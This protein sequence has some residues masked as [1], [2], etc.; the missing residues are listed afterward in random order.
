MNGTDGDI[1]RYFLQ[2]TQ[3]RM[4]RKLRIV[5]PCHD[6]SCMKNDWRKTIDFRRKRNDTSINTI[7]RGPK[8]KKCP[9]CGVSNSDKATFCLKCGAKLVK[10]K[11]QP[12][13]TRSAG[14][15]GLAITSMVLGICSLP[16]SCCYFTGIIPAI[17]AVVFGFIARKKIKESGGSIKGDG[18]AIA[19][20]ATGL[21]TIGIFVISIAVF[22][23]S[24]GLSGTI[25]KEYLNQMNQGS[26]I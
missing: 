2:P 13:N 23:I 4:Q 8:M 20:I 10:R 15:N 1:E 24:G 11:K 12:S 25:W 3:F 17:L 21:C 6:S 9:T 7:T 16:L 5:C 26:S 18:I 19:G 14:T 22:F